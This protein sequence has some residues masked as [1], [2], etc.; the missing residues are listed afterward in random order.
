MKQIV[1][2]LSALTTLNFSLPINKII[3]L[4][5]WKEMREKDQIDQKKRIEVMS[6]KKKNNFWGDKI[7]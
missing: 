4:T 3:F 1:N 6:R 7:M 2:H 5:L